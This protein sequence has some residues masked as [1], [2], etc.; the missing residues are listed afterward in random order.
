M[1]TYYIFL[2]HRQSYRG[3]TKKAETAARTLRPERPDLA[4][5]D[6]ELGC[7]VP[8]IPVLKGMHFHFVGQVWSPWLIGRG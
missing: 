1:G 8:M 6:S 5:S 2:N 7:W 3:I 4:A